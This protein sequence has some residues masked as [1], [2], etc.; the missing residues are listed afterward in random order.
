MIL[1]AAVGDGDPVDPM[2]PEDGDLLN[3]R[4]VLA[5]LSYWRNSSRV[6]R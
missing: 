4:I 5:A 1:V 2:T 6:L 3:G